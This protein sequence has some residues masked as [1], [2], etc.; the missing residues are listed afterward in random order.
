MA[1]PLGNNGGRLYSPLFQPVLIDCNFIVDSSNGNG[2]GIRS[3][4]GQGVRNVFM[5]TSATP[6]A[7]RGYTNPNPAAGY[8]LIQLD[9]N[10]QRYC[11]GYSGFISPVTGSNL[12]INSTAL[13]AGVPYVITA[14]GA[15]SNGAATITTVADVSGSLASTYFSVYD[16]YG[17]TFVIWFSVSGVGNAP[18]GVS[19]TLVQQT[20]SSGASANT[21]ASALVLTL[22]N[23]PISVGSATNSFTAGASSNVVTITSTIAQPLAGVPQDGASPLATG[24]SFAQTV[25]ATNLQC[26]QGVGLPKGLIPTVGQSFIATATGYTTGGSSSGTVKAS[27]ISD[28]TSIE[29]IGDPNQS[30]GPAP[31]GGSANT[32]G[33]ILVQFLAPTSSSTTTLVPTAPAN[34]STVGLS[35]LVE[36]K[37]VS[38]NGE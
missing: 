28:I 33:F 10:Y 20:I 23:L 2:L 19:G 1:N 37:S 25:Y 14:T 32:G 34:N 7:N 29:V 18:T 38:V 9:A 15:A 27:A 13:T 30:M 17:N 4:K 35:F 12:A 5:H 21:I 16:S 22:E 8:A 6:A 11:G 31:M 36:F 24:F 3:L 26:W